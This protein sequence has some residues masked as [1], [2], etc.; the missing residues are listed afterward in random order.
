VFEREHESGGYFAPHEKPEELV[1]DL[2]KMFGKGGSAFGII[3]GKDGY[4]ASV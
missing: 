2:R 4:A 3:E 1:N